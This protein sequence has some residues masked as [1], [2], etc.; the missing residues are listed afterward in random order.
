MIKI[1]SSSDHIPEG[2]RHKGCQ[3][4]LVGVV[5]VLL[6]VLASGGQQG[7][8]TNLQE[9]STLSFSPLPGPHEGQ[10]SSW[11]LRATKSNGTVESNLR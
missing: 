5:G 7:P 10:M 4:R 6:Q 1:C 8:S 11:S 2:Q 9:L 3:G